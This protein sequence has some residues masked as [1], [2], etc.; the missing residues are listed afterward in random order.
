MRARY[1]RI[2]AILLMCSMLTACGQE[3][4]IDDYATNEGYETDETDEGS[5]G[6]AEGETVARGGIPVDEIKVGVIHLSD[7]AEGSGYTYTH[8]LGIQ[9]MQQ[10]LGLSDDQILRKINVSDSDEAQ[11][12]QA[13]RD[14]ID[15]GCNIIF[16]TSWGIWRRLL[17]LQRN[18]RMFISHMVQAI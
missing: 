11:T 17:R 16:A 6:S 7:P 15:E 18:I 12:E 8:D 9:G 2:G 1:K 14:C 5:A 10:N 3:T 4:V 13:L